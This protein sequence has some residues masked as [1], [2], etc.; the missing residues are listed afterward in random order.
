[1]TGHP[2]TYG[3]LEEEDFLISVQGQEVFDMHHSQ[4]VSLI[5]N[6]GDCLNMQVER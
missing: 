5:K 2:A 3:G 1:M 6:A 4:V